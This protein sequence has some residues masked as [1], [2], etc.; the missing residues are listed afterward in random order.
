MAI[1]S[2]EDSDKL[3]D[4]IRAISADQGSNKESTRDDQIQLLYSLL[5]PHVNIPSTIGSEGEV[6]IVN[7][8]RTGMEYGTVGVAYSIED[9][10]GNILY[11]GIVS[12]SLTQAITNSKITLKNSEATIQST[13]EVLS[14]QDLE[15]T[16]NDALVSVKN[17]VG[18]LLSGASYP[19]GTS[20]DTVLPDISL[21]DSDGTVLPKAVGVDLVCTPSAD[22]TVENSDLSYTNTVASGG[23]LILPDVTVNATNSNGTELATADIPSVQDH[24][25]SIA[26]VD[27]SVNASSEGQVPVGDIDITIED[28]A[29]APITP[30]SDYEA[31][32][33]VDFFTLSINNVF[34]NTYRFTDELGGQTFTNN[35]IID[36]STYNG[37][38]EVLGWYN[39]F[40]VDGNWED[41]ID[42]AI[43]KSLGGFTSGW[44]MA[45]RNELNS[46]VNCEITPVLNYPPFSQNV[47]L[48]VY[49]STTVPNATT[50]SYYMTLSNGFI[51]GFTKTSNFGGR[52]MVCRNFTVIGTTL[53]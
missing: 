3:I 30:D 41:S 53:T 11:S 5:K 46:I 33:D 1:Q 8:S 51:G 21:T 36:W 4:V 40:Q 37:V 38:D 16:A 34:G 47:N 45:N 31:G 52:Q 29:A 35:I 39:V 14:Q 25:L 24:T 7:A 17:T 44:R 19:S 48:N 43:V 27:V 26:D 22:A 15:L 32:R 18:T 23:T 28:T 50:Q 6:L 12:G 42:A 20:T 10:A 13:T 2:S 49:M 9:S